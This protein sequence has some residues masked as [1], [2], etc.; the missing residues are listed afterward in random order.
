MTVYVVT[1]EDRLRRIR[2]IPIRYCVEMIIHKAIIQL[3]TLQA[4]FGVLFYA[5]LH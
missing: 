4:L 2:S 1:G 5:S 3:G